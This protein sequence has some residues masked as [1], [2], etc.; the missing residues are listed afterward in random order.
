VLQ[1]EVPAQA[2]LTGVAMFDP[3]EAQRAP[4]A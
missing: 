3:A 2:A 4:G 1:D